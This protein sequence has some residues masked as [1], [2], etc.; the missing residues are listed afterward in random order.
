[1][2]PTL[3]REELR[4]VAMFRSSLSGRPC[5]SFIPNLF[6]IRE[7]WSPDSSTTILAQSRLL[8]SASPK[9]KNLTYLLM[10]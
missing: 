3:L 6:G 10:H 4:W 1:M 2:G 5:T 8:H 7:A 9:I